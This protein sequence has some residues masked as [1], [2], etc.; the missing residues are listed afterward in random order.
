MSH[1]IG[2]GWISKYVAA[3]ILLVS[4][5]VSAPHA[6]ADYVLFSQSASQRPVEIESYSNGINGDQNVIAVFDDFTIPIDAEL[7]GVS[8]TGGFIGYYAGA[9]VSRFTIRFYENLA[10]QPGALLSSSVIVGNANEHYST[11]LNKNTYYTQLTNPILVSMHNSYWMSIVAT[12]DNSLNLNN[13][14]TWGWGVSQTTPFSPFPPYE[15]VIAYYSYDNGPRYMMSA[16]MSFAISGIAVPEPQGL[17]AL[18]LGLICI[19]LMKLSQ[20]AES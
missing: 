12:V 7:T 10:N 5:W 18:G 2:P 19:F 17:I 8:W 9:S 14:A 15:R 3:M 11:F 16:N 13:T 20:E 6:A 1:R 4:F